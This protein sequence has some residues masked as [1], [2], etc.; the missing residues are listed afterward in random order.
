M[1]GV[2]EAVCPNESAQRSLDA[3]RAVIAPDD[4]AFGYYPFA[5]AL[6]DAIRKTPSPTGVVMALN[7]P[8]GSGK[9][10]LMNLIKFNLAEQNDRKTLVVEFNPWWFNGRDQLAGQLLTQF[11]KAL[12]G[13]SGALRDAGDA[14][15]KYAGMLSKAVA[16]STSIPWLDKVLTPLLKL[17][18]RKP[19]DVPKTKAKISGALAKADRRVLILVDDIDRLTPS[20]M[21]EVFKVVKA[22]GDFPNVIYL[23]SFDRDVVAEAIGKAVSADGQAY[24]E[25]IVQAS[26]DL[27]T[28]SQAQ[29]NAHFSQ[30]LDKLLS[31]MAVPAV[32]PRYFE[33]VFFDGLEQYLQKPRDIV[34][35]LNILRVTFPA[36]VGEVNWVDFVALEFLRLFEPIAYQKIRQHPGMCTGAPG[37]SEDLRPVS[38]F[39]EAW[40]GEVCEFRRSG[41]RALMC[42]M[43]PKIDA[44]FNRQY[45]GG[46]DGFRYMNLSCAEFHPVYFSF[47]VPDTILSRAQADELIALAPDV[48]RF[49]DA[50]LDLKKI[51]RQDGHSKARELLDFIARLPSDTAHERAGELLSAILSVPESLLTEADEAGSF[52]MP[53]SWRITG[54]L[55][56]LLGIIPPALRA[57]ALHSAVIQAREIPAASHLLR[58]LRTD[59]PHAVEMEGL[60]VAAVQHLQQRLATQVMQM[61]LQDLLDFDDQQLLIHILV[62]VM[63]EQ[64]LRDRYQ[65]ILSDPPLLLRFLEGSVSTGSLEVQGDRVS[66]RVLNVPSA[67]LDRITGRDHARTLV[68]ALRTQPGMSPSQTQVI[69]AYLRLD[70]LGADDATAID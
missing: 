47:G 28:I 15:A 41:V 31:A 9:S 52:S 53:N 49:A 22:L 25:K 66:R 13:E 7:G 43:F 69:E 11:H 34:R 60:D 27:P 30:E 17:L 39:H 56:H 44:A 14:L 46:Y 67:A 33:N 12:S 50:W 59:L 70:F 36:V 23:L 3:D 55:Q 68:E 61:S 37:M 38:A 26:F 32:A 19:V 48:G 2:D 29:L 42:R 57:E 51:R 63:G 6:T 35:I 20:E 62:E 18:G 10:S 40:L 8:W 45:Y 1:A 54:T 5:K 65:P 21:M 16:Y 58:R 4:D 24:L 64:H